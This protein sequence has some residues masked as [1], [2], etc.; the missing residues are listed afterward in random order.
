MMTIISTITHHHSS[1]YTITSNNLPSPLIIHITTNTTS[2]SLSSPSFQIIPLACPSLHLHPS[3]PTLSITFLHSLHFHHQFITFT[4]IIY[5]QLQTT[6]EWQG[7]MGG[8]EIKRE[9]SNVQRLH[10]AIPFPLSLPFLCPRF[11]LTPSLLIPCKPPTCVAL[12]ASR[13]SLPPS[14]SACTTALRLGLAFHSFP[15]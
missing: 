13:Y 15:W 3:N 2:H 5:R 11:C 12:S 8:E 4:L 1:L 9:A 14:S 6:D 10:T 7:K